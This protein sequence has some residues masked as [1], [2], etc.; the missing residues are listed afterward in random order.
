[1]GSLLGGQA[2]AELSS[3]TVI[4]HMPLLRGTWLLCIPTGRRRVMDEEAM[5]S[6][7]LPSLGVGR[8][9]LK[10]VPEKWM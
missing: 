6:A 7:A 2:A 1:M 4:Q 10:P 8:F 3:L 5:C 9:A